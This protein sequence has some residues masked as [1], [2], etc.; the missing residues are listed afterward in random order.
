MEASL[1]C[2]LLIDE[3]TRAN[4]SIVVNVAIFLWIT[5]RKG[6]SQWA[7]IIRLQNAEIAISGLSC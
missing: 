2:E 7:L 4:D 3:G 6:S 1:Y 5:Y